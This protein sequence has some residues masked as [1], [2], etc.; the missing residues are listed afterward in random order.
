MK[1]RLLLAL[2]LAA[3]PL[4]SCKDMTRGIRLADAAA[5]DF[6][7]RFNERKFK[8]IYAAAHADLKAATTEAEFVKLLEAVHRKLGKHTGNSSSGWRINSHNL[9][10]TVALTQDAVFEQGK[11]TEVFTFVISGESCVLQDYDIESKDMMLK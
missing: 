6:H 5:D 1:R 10:T 9:K 7:Q 11:G 3:L 4:A 2:P 8:E